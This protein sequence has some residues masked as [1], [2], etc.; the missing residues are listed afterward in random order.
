[1]ELKIK[2]RIRTV[3][4]PRF[5]TW[6]K[7]R[8]DLVLDSA[9]SKIKLL[10]QCQTVCPRARGQRTPFLRMVFGVVG[11]D[12]SRFT[13]NAKRKIEKGSTLATTTTIDRFVYIEWIRIRIQ[14]FKKGILTPKRMRIVNT[15]KWV[16][17][18][19]AWKMRHRV[20]VV[21]NTRSF[22]CRMGHFKF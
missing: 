14:V 7:Y 11:V 17:I 19:C 3:G 2:G 21:A 4:R 5:V 6:W 16:I 22:C 20:V 13:V 1:M 15:I 10:I 8:C 18:L 9:R 12:R